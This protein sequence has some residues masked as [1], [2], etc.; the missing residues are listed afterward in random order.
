MYD[1]KYSPQNR[2]KQQRLAA[3]THKALL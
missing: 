3:L 1:L 2:S